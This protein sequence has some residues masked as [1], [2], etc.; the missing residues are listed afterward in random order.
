MSI[1]PEDHGNNVHYSQ[2]VE[3]TSSRG[4]IEKVQDAGLSDGHSIIENDTEKNGLERTEE[5]PLSLA[6]TLLDH[7]DFPDGGFRAWLVVVGVRDCQLYE[8]QKLTFFAIRL[9]AMN[10]PRE[11]FDFCIEGTPKH[12]DHTKIWICE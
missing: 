5:A 12:T 1:Q 4:S 7:E 6:T 9:F 10:F 8:L 2:A 3:N 11:S